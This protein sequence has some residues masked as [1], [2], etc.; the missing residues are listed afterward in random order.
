MEL[1]FC[2]WIFLSPEDTAKNKTK[3]NPTLMALPLYK[4]RQIENTSKKIQTQT[5]VC[6]GVDID[7]WFANSAKHYEETKAD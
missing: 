5:Y 4:E 2:V 7:I 6:L 3:K 1:A